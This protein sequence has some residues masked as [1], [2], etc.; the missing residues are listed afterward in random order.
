MILTD[1]H[2]HLDLNKFD[3][4]RADVIRRAEN[5]GIQRILIPGIT[6][7]SSRSAVELA[8]SYPMLYAA[9]GVH[10]SDSLTW[11]NATPSALGE[12]AIHPKVV[13]IGEIGLDYYWEGAP[14]EH[15]IRVLREQLELAA[16][17]ELPVVLHMREAKDA[18]HGKCAEDLLEILKE[19]VA[20]FGNR[21]APAE[22]SE[23]HPLAGR[24][25][26][27]HSFAGSLETAQRAI[28]LNFLI[29]VTGPV[30]FENARRRQEIIAAIPMKYLLIET[31]TPYLTPHPYRGKRNEPSYVELVAGKIA[32]LHGISIDEVARIT[33]ANATKLFHW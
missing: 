5:A 6:L 15:Q 17:L 3:A 2:C 21:P 4:D 1:T 16:A 12:L 26:V 11:D 8:G 14:A 33:T 24:P 25:G 31:D 23:K 9:I 20:G 22:G 29:G 30:T 13:A 7:D 19:W 18:L 32:T 27:L 10:P 28:D